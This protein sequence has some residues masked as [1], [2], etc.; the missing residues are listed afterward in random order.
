M[1]NLGL[2]VVLLGAIALTGCLENGGGTEA[3]SNNNNGD[4]SV[5]TEPPPEEPDSGTGGGSTGGGD[6]GGTVPQPS[7][8]NGF[9]INKGEVLTASNNLLLDFYPPFTS[10]YTKVSEDET[11]SSGT[12]ASFVGSRYH[13]SSKTNQSV[14]LSVQFRDHDG[15]TSVCYVRRIFIDQAGPEIVF[16]KYPSAPVEEGTDVEV[17]FSVTD[18]GAGV[19]SVTCMVGAVSKPCAAGTN[20]IVFPKL[21]GGEYTLK[22]SATDKFNQSSEKSVTFTVTS[23]YK[24]MVQNVKVN[25]YQKV[26]ILFVIDN[27]GSMEYEQKSM[28]SRV[29]NFLDVVK[30]LDWQIAVTTT[31]PSNST[32]GD[33]RLVPIYG[34]T[35]NYILNSSMSDTVARNALGMT[36]Q[37]PETGSGDEQGI[38]AA[39]R[40]IE[41]SLASTATNKNFIRSDSQLA[42]VLISDEDE[43]ANGAKNDPANFV[44]YVQTAFNGQKSVSFHSIIARPDD[45]ACLSGEGYSAGYR[46]EQISKLTGGVIGDVCATDYAAQVQGIAEG[47]RQTLKSITLSCAPVIDSMRSLLVLKDG[48][49]YNGAR[50][51]NGVNVVFN[52]MLPKG[53]YE[54]YY[55]C[56]K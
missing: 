2:I 3:P 48:Q 29:R 10:A 44:K 18:P 26:D 8:P 17:V 54:V 47:V 52:D 23:L 27:S 56:L 39:Y 28:A 16:A 24:Q 15:R 32:L 35:N 37:R 7:A 13:L 31:D 5:I 36:L 12:F 30:G 6:N 51:I 22:V 53:D 42:V 11:C 38:Y 21:A 4:F 1:K 46:Y 45:K 40:A 33:G 14:P 19:Q 43:S 20:K 25:E 34:Q 50:T 9:D 55:S 49:V 41:R